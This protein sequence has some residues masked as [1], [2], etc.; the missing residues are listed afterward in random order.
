VQE[1]VRVPP[2]RAGQNLAEKQLHR[3]ALSLGLRGAN[4]EGKTAVNS[5]SVL[6]AMSKESLQFWILVGSGTFSA[7]VLLLLWVTSAR[8]L[9][10][11]R[12]ILRELRNTTA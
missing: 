12:L 3:R 6:A 11:S 1:S 8:Y 7:F 10:A 9:A 2:S 4:K 5:V